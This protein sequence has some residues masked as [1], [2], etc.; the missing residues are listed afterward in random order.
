MAEAEFERDLQ[1]MFDAA[2]PVADAA[3]FALRV[4][5]RIA[6]GQWL[7]LT[8]VL[9]FGVLGLIVS[10]AAFGRSTVDFAPVFASMVQAAHGS[11]AA[12]GDT[13]MWVGVLLLAALGLIALRP[14]LAEA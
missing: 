7:R 11:P 1:A 10:L 8:I 5:R 3:A 9:G 14:A 6:R 2:P 13:S 12:L 4:D